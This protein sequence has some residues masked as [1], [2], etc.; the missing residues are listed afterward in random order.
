[1]A[2]K[3][4]VI[5]DDA[6]MLRVL[7]RML[8]ISGFQVLLANTGEAGLALALADRPDLVLS[9][10]TMPGMTGYEVCRHLRAHP[11]LNTTRF[12]LF[13]GLTG[14]QERAAGFAA[15]ADEYLYKPIAPSDLVRK[16][17]EVL[18]RP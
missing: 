3:I 8:R 10:V 9:D 14:G 13:S 18:A 1:M 5:D 6:H 12:I 16:I 2:A 11:D 4:L 17:R 15:G 7:D